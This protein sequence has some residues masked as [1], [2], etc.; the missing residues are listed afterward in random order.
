MAGMAASSSTAD[1][2]STRRDF[3]PICN[4]PPPLAPATAFKYSNHG[5]ALLGKVIES[6]TGRLYGDWIAERVVAAAGLRET[7]P[8]FEA[9]TSHPFARGHTTR[10]P[11]GQ[12]FVIPG[13]NPT[14][15]MASATGFVATAGDL[16]RFFA[17]LAP[18]AEKSFLTAASRREM[19]RRHWRD[20]H[21][22][23]EI[24]QGLGTISGPAGPWG[25][26]G[27]SGGFQGT[28]SRTATLP[29]QGI[30]ISVLTNAIDGLAGV[31]L[32]GVIH[33]LKTFHDLGAPSSETAA[34]R[35]R[36]WSSWGA[37][38]LVPGQEKV[39][40]ALPALASPFLDASELRLTGIDTAIVTKSTAFGDFGEDCRL[41]RDASGAVE[42]VRIGGKRLVSESAI[43]AEVSALYGEITGEETVSVA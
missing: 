33:I 23:Q 7:S 41:V 11:H 5:F 22:Q 38:D 31:W 24:H 36:W 1:L 2:S 12:R 20:A 34:W 4:L 17:Q 32:D 14:N 35:G 8:D 27:H 42:Q 26:V 28:I 19:I 10:W 29:E 9:S 15:A 30:T 40:I 13:D 21:S 39:L 6:I 3:A 43:K 18:T 16:A 37:A 25:W